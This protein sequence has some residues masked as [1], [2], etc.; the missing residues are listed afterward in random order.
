[1]GVGFAESYRRFPWRKAHAFVRACLQNSAVLAAFGYSFRNWLQAECLA[2]GTM[3]F[4]PKDFRMPVAEGS[5]LERRLVK[6]LEETFWQVGPTLAPYIICDWQLWLWNEGRTGVFEN[7]KPD[8]FH[9]H[10][11]ER[12]GRGVIPLERQAFIDWWLDSYPDLPP[13]LVN[14]CIW[15]AIEQRMFDA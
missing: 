15:L 9:V 4:P 12:Y 3:D 11:A 6:R 1:M 7:F 14:E 8:L 10:F 13:R 5:S 2:M